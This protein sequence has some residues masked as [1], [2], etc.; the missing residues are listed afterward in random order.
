MKQLVNGLKQWVQQISSPGG[1]RG[2]RVVKSTA[3]THHLRASASELQLIWWR[4][5]YYYLEAK[6]LDLTVRRRQGE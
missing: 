3:V 5:R 4:W 1:M 6:Q 2:G